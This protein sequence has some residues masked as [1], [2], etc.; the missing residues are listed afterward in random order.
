MKSLLTLMTLLT[1]SFSALANDSMALEQLKRTRNVLMMQVQELEATIFDLENRH[2]TADV[3]AQI[4]SFEYRTTNT[5]SR[6]IN[7]IGTMSG[8]DLFRD[9]TAELLVNGEVL[10]RQELHFINITGN[11]T[12]NMRF[13]LPQRYDLNAAGFTL[14]VNGKGGRTKEFP[15]NC[16]TTWNTTEGHCR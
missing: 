3:F 6:W 16:V 13:N 4:S 10:T 11:Y 1:L 14:R 9:A 7:L 12:L 5:N 8:D 15:L 2:Y